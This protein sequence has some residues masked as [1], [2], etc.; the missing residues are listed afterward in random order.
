MKS[1]TRLGISLLAG[2]AAAGVAYGANDITLSTGTQFLPG[3]RMVDGNDLNIMLGVIN[4]VQ[5]QLDGTKSVGGCVVV[6]PQATP[7][8][9]NGVRGTVVT[10]ALTNA[11]GANFAYTINNNLVTAA[12]VI[13]CTLQ[14]YSG[15]YTT[16][17]IPIIVSCVP[18]AGSFIVNLGNAHG[19]NALNGTVKIGFVITN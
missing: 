17:G 18:G 14:A 1:I 8:T 6:G 10:T 13:D 3:P 19:A 12:S 2:L 11:A 4:K 5:D 7:A 15:T 16:N 9:C